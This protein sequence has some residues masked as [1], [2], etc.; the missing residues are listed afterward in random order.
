MDP[1]S[2]GVES[3]ELPQFRVAGS[4]GHRRQLQEMDVLLMFSFTG[5]GSVV[6]AYLTPS[7]LWILPGLADFQADLQ[8]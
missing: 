7:G 6:S 5:Q 3:V 8:R 2:L 4:E 1:D